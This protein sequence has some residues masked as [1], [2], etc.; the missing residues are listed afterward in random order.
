MKKLKDLNLIQFVP[1][2]FICSMVFQSIFGYTQ[3]V[4]EPKKKDT[5]VVEVKADT[6]KSGEGGLDLNKIKDGTYEGTGT[7]FRG[8]VKVSVT[9]KEHKIT[10]IKIV[11]NSD[12]AS[13]FNRASEGVIP[14]IIER[15]SLDVDVVSGA[16]YSSKG[17]LAA[18]KN[19]LTGEVD[20]SSAKGNSL[21]TKKAKKMAAVKESGN[22]KDG[23][24][25]GTGTGF[26]G[27]MKVAVTIKNSRIQK[28][29]VLEKKDDAAYFERAKKGVLSAIIKKQTTN[30]DAVSGA[31]FSSN[32]LIEA[33][34]NALK[35]AEKKQKDP[36]TE[37]TS[38]EE[39]NTSLTLDGEYKN[40]TFKGTGTGFRGEIEA[41][42]KIKKN[43]M[44]SIQVKN[45][46]DDQSF[47]ERACKVIT[48]MLKLQKA[49]VD[50]VSGATYSS[51]GIIQAVNE[52]LKKASK[53][54]TTTEEEEENPPKE[55]EEMKVYTGSA[56]CYPD[57]DE[58]FTEYTLTLEIAVKD[59]T[60][61]AIRNIKGAGDGYMVI[62][63]DYIEMAQEGLIPDLLSGKSTKECDAVSGATCSSKAIL[64]A[65]DD[66]VSKME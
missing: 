63:D 52:A 66:A 42:V 2:I 59:G 43:R 62:N 44:V 22:Y 35:K 14:L 6:T 16:T 11:S 47:F 46:K 10:E 18:V 5:G 36:T 56:I 9:V 34:R 50:V 38:T 21:Q 19:A 4:V 53:N 25:T 26:R 49:D 65:Y 1:V 20:E 32:G 37:E 8:P 55:D 41:S 57:E 31:T 64:N 23:T 29:K 61:M 27:A 30:V 28:I 7:G 17:I 12:D 58:D 39:T 24:F 51:K 40:G 45:E 13:F 48:S 60:V 3:P 33:V 15:Q 54:E